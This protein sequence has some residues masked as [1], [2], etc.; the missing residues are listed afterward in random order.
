MIRGDIKGYRA[1]RNFDITPEPGGGR[2][3]SDGN[4]FVIQ[5]H[6]ARRLHYDLRLQFGDVLKSWAITKGPSLDPAVKRLAAHVEEHPL[7]YANFE[8]TIPKG[9][10]GAGAVIVWDRGTWAPMRD[11]DEDYEKGELKIRLAGEKLRGGWTLVR[12]KPD[13]HSGDPWLLVKE[14]DEYMRPT[15]DGDILEEQPNSVLTGRS[16]EAVAAVPEKPRAPRRRRKVK[17][18]GLHGAR[19]VSMPDWIPPQLPAPRESPPTGDDWLHEIKFDGYRSMARL[20][21]GKVLFFTRNGLDWTERYGSLSEA[22]AGLRCKEAMIDGEIV[23]QDERGVSSFTALQEALAKGATEHLVFYAFDLLYLDGYDLT[24]VPLIK[25]KETL[26]A[27]LSQVVSD[28]SGLQLSE[29]VVDQGPE[30]LAQARGMS[31]EGIVSKKR[32]SSY[33]GRRTQTWIKVKCVNT[34]DFVIV[35]FTESKAA[36]GLSA[37]LLAEEGSDGLRYVGKVGTGFSTKEAGQLLKRLQAIQ[38]AKPPLTQTKGMKRSAAIWVKPTLVAEVRFSSRTGDGRLRHPVYK[39]LR[40]D[41]SVFDSAT[42]PAARLAERRRYVTDADLASIWVT[43]PDRVMF[44]GPTK[45]E[46]ALY[47]ARVGN[48]ILPELIGRP[49]S[50]VRC[51]TGEKS[52]CFFQRHASPGMPETVKAVRLREQESQKKEG[53][54][55]VECARGLLSLAQFG[56]IEF[57]PW[58]CRVDKP[59]RPDRMIFDLDPDENLR[60]RDVVDAAMEIRHR[61]NQ[62]ALKCF[63]KTSGSKGLHIVV[64]LVRRHS[65]AEVRGFSKAFAAM[66][67]KQAPKRFTSSMS[68]R[69]RRGRIYIDYLRNVRGATTVAAYSLRGATGVPVS[70]PVGWDELSEI[71]DP[72]DLNYVT[73]P[74]RL[75]KSFRDPWEDI[76]RAAHVLTLDMARK[77]EIR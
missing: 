66:M 59:E 48:W 10:Y 1:K 24:E 33:R 11:P 68:M 76:D 54:L 60:W 56:T 30:F 29:H 77:L 58:G 70:T 5:K 72:A 71:D 25:R 73:V 28:K 52:D 20:E 45:L 75:G 74:D 41:K 21:G 15:S 47:Y 12:L 62:V 40:P 55:Y 65:W 13:R 2:S 19:Q 18:S 39:G 32:Y 16:V 46:L 23:V 63:A 42:R 35:G 51:T 26:M 7:E 8:G 34:E 17:P 6:A 36:G 3:A 31:L 9:E 43:N 57:H 53:Y 64:P 44:G 27:L 14:R 49:L 22:F 37:L 4:I 67:A 69:S 38:Q 61:L 50:L